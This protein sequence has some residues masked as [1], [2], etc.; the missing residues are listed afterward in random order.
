MPYY[1]GCVMNQYSQELLC[2]C[3]KPFSYQVSWP[4]GTWLCTRFTSLLLS[5]VMTIKAPLFC[6]TVIENT[7]PNVEVK[8]SFFRIILKMKTDHLNYYKEL[9]DSCIS[10]DSDWGGEI[11][12]F[13]CLLLIPSCLPWFFFSFWLWALSVT[14][15]SR[16]TGLNTYFGLLL[17]TTL[18]FTLTL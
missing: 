8:M 11:A 1:I 12:R 2:H 14:L 17:S 16:G 4:S 10:R 13:F 3:C 7:S 6:A 15:G 18:D 9:I 5:C